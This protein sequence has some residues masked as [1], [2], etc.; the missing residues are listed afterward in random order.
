VSEIGRST[1]YGHI[2]SFDRLSS[3]IQNTNRRNIFQTI[4]RLCHNNLLLRLTHPTIKGR[5]PLHYT[6]VI[7]DRPLFVRSHFQLSAYLLRPFVYSSRSPSSS[8]VHV[9]FRQSTRR[10]FR[11]TLFYTDCRPDAQPRLSGDPY[12]GHDT[13]SVKTRLV[14]PRTY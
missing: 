9:R 13:I 12:D 8:P 14:T 7:P 4:A 2:R 11:A 5:P 3:I 6:S 10:T 1:I